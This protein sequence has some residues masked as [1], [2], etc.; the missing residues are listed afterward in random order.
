MSL[1]EK[2]ANE[3]KLYA[4]YDTVANTHVNGIE[5]WE[6]RVT[7]NNLHIYI[8]DIEPMAKYFKHRT[9][10]LVLGCSIGYQVW[11]LRQ[12][13]FDAYGCDISQWALDRAIVK[14][15]IWC[16]INKMP[17]AD[18]EFDN[19]IGT[20]IMEHIPMEWLDDSIREIKRVVKSK[21]LF[22]IP[23]DHTNVRWAFKIEKVLSEHMINQDEVWWS[24]QF[25]KY[26][27]CKET[28]WFQEEFPK[29]WRYYLYEED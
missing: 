3:K 10:V 20:D 23:F 29:F 28:I 11:A 4:F 19:V 6:T 26:F 12:L 27:L 13:G 17:Y 21:V 16:N 18:G 1:D 5:C 14:N 22:R 24:A 25:K 2:I 9:K 8:N 15:C 7:E